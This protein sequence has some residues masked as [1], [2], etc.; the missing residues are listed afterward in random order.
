M[1][2]PSVASLPTLNSWM[3]S[4]HIDKFL[5]GMISH[6]MHVMFQNLNHN[7]LYC[8]VVAGTELVF[9]RASDRRYTDIVIIQI[10]GTLTSLVVTSEPTLC[11]GSVII[12]SKMEIS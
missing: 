7:K 3:D 6:E 9:H 12:M 8:S 2:N 10:P 1:C 4:Q 5:P 11:V